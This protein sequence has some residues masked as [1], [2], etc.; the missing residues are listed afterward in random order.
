MSWL[1]DSIAELLIDS[2]MATLGSIFGGITDVVNEA[3]LEVGITPGTWN[4]GVFSMVENL[5]NTVILPIAGIVL[6]RDNANRKKT[7]LSLEGASA[8]Q[9]MYRSV[10]VVVAYQL[11]A[12]CVTPITGDE[13]STGNPVAPKYGRQQNQLRASLF[14]RCHLI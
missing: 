6:S 13:K 8:N 5:S 2:I 4:P 14:V 9:A 3:A 10:E 12:A 1:F 11:Y 7:T